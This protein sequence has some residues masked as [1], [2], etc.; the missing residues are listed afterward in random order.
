MT[1][2]FIM[3]PIYGLFNIVSGFGQNANFPFLPFFSMVPFHL[4]FVVASAIKL[5]PHLR[6][7]ALTLNG[8]KFHM[9]MYLDHFQNWLDFGRYLL[10]F[11]I[12]RH[13]N[14][15]KQVKLAIF[16]NLL[17]TAG[18]EWPRISHVDVFW[19]PSELIVFWSWSVD[20]PHF[21]VIL[22]ETGLIWGFRGFSSEHMGDYI[23]VTG[24]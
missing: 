5:I 16:R 7:I 23:L 13:F 14:Y 3:I 4:V 1:L 12:W 2:I 20:F 6:F 21:G 8:P 19:P 11:L 9:L 24:C 18:E 15:M 17:E 22:T 10:I